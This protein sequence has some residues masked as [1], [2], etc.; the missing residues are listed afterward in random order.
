MTSERKLYP[1]I[2]ERLMALRKR[3]S[4]LSQKAWAEKHG[5]KTTQ[6]NNWENGTRRI[7]L[8][9]AEKLCELYGLTLD[10]LYR[11]SH[12]ENGWLLKEKI[13]MS[14]FRDAVL[15]IIQSRGISLRQLA[16]DADVSYELLKKQRP[17][18][19]INVEDAIK[20]ASSLGMTI[21]QVVD[22]NN[23]EASK[24]FYGMI[25][26][27]FIGTAPLDPIE[28]KKST[29]SDVAEVERRLLTLFGRLTDDEKE[30]VLDYIRK[31]IEFGGAP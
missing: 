3:F 15:D 1:E 29:Q 17:I 21:N 19:K 13:C 22:Y 14:N 4:D 10:A 28:H 2:G 27:Q 24:H 9:A 12:P 31:L 20:L 11:G 16:I 30:V 8:E 18:Q 7:P 6:Y 23:D 26:E 25:D 5:F